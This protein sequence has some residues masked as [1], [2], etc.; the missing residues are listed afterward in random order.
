[1]RYE[2]K[3]TVTAKRVISDVKFNQSM[4]SVKSGKPLT[5]CTKATQSFF[6]EYCSPEHSDRKLNKSQSNKKKLFATGSFEDLQTY[7]CQDVLQ[8]STLTSLNA[9]A[10]RNSPENRFEYAEKQITR[11]FRS[12]DPKDSVSSFQPLNCSLFEK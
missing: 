1:M 8:K 2:P 6:N 11:N 3:E 10:Y 9:F 5:L 4:H 7:L 12:L